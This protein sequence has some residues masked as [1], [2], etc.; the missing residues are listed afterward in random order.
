MI[1]AAAKRSD[2]RGFALLIVL[3]TLV[4]LAL[5]VTE[6]GASGRTESRIARNLMANAAA[7]A[8]ADGA[9]HQA[10]FHLADGSDQGWQPDGALRH[11]MVGPVAVEV[12]IEDEA[13]KVNPNLADPA[14]LQAVLLVLG[15]DQRLAQSVAAGIIDWR[16]GIPAEQQAGV[17]QR[18]Q[19]AGLAYRPSFSPFESVDDVGLVLGLPP[20]LAARLLPHLSVHQIGIADPARADPVVARALAQLPGGTGPTP[21]AVPM[22]YRSVTITAIAQPVGG[23]GFTRRA[24]VRIGPGLPHGYALLVWDAPGAQ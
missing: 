18:Y 16:G 12:R 9:V 3:W 7:E 20:A 13:G 6:L 10:I 1:M 11:L 22:A 19:A 14:L 5:I 4:L 24:L 15:A 2:H 21:P 23:G 17:S 8:A